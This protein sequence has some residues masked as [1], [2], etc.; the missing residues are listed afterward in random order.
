MM[1]WMQEYFAACPDCAIDLDLK[2]SVSWV[3]CLDDYS[4]F[5]P[6]FS[7]GILNRYR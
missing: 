3:A 2:S 6:Y 5:N 7:C 1:D 4:S